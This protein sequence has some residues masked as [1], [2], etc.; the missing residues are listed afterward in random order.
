MTIQEKLSVC[1]KPE[2]QAGFSQVYSHE[3]GCN[4]WA[5]FQGEVDFWDPM[6]VL[7]DLA[8]VM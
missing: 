6:E 7:E 5:G 8:L 2:I 1:N 3:E 4:A